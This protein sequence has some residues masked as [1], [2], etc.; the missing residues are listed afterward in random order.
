MKKLQ[1]LN[2]K[3]KKYIIFDMDGT[4]IDSIGVWNMTDQ[5]LIKKYGNVDVDLN[6]VQIQRDNFLHNNQ[7]SDIY[8]E[9][10]NYLIDKYNLNIKDF[11]ELVKIRWSI[12]GHILENEIDFKPHVVELI[13]K[14]KELGFIVILATMTTDTQLDIYANKNKNMYSKMNIYEVFDYIITKDNVQKKKPNPEIYL[15]IMEYYST[16]ASECLI[17][18]D[19]YT[20]I[21]AS[22]AANIEVVNIYDK[23]ADVD[24]K[25]INSLTDYK[26]ENFKEFLDYVDSIYSVNKQKKLNNNS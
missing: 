10:C 16:N 22:K 8:R 26:I 5:K 20:G 19:S 21:L 12:S 15:K 24:R 25:E 4:L 7:S 13:Y 2:L 3:E 9:Y 6:T 14:L 18:E 11:D 1:D 17:F 23:Y